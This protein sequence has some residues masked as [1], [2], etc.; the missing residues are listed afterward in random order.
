LVFKSVPEPTTRM[1]M[2]KKGEVDLA[3]DDETV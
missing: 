1:A 2:I 3:A